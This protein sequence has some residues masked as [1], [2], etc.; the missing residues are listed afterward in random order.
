MISQGLIIQSLISG[1]LMGGIYAAMGVGFS[2]TWGVMKVINLSH[3][4]FGV[5]SAYIGYW[6]LKNSGVDPLL[7]L[8]VIVP[9]LFVIGAGVYELLIKRIQHSKDITVSSMLLCFGL[10]ILI[11]NLM[12]Y[13]WSA[14]PRVM[15]TR[16]IGESF[17]VGGISFS[18][19]SVIGFILA[20]SCLAAIYFFLH[21]TYTGKAVQAVWQEREGSALV[22][23]NIDRVSMITFGLAIAS[24][25]VG[26]VCMAF[27]YSFYPSLH[28]VW[29]LFMFLVVIVGGV[30][31]VVG[32]AAGGLILGIVMGLSGA[33]I[34]YQWVNAIVFVLLIIILLIK[35]QGLFK[36]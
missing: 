33:L 23:I 28:N 36:V 3:C 18:I 25:G 35:P 13:A 31:S 6:L 32:T 21:K 29:L 26:G 12:L 15:N 30:G 9:M 5:V 11:E 16:Y 1:I 8:I 10:G 7:S 24:A 27:M 4:A 17:F 20:M 19:P 14:S 34:S 2:L 22:G